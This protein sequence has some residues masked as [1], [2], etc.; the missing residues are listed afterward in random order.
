MTSYSNLYETWYIDHG[1]RV[2]LMK[3][4]FHTLRV[5]ELI[6]QPIKFLRQNLIIV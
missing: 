3:V 6:L 5:V 2:I 4:N 1:T